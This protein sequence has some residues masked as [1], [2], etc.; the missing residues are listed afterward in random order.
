METAIQA[1]KTKMVFD[2]DD[3]LTVK[4]DNYAKE[5]DLDRAKVLRKA[6]RNFFN[7]SPVQKTG[8]KAS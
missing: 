5:N 1:T 2:L 7:Q 6:V 8:K 3:E 4:V